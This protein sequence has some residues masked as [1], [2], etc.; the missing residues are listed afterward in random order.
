V[1]DQ[2][3]LFGG[4]TDAP[5]RERV[6]TDLASTVFVEAGAGT[7][8]TAV[9]VDRIVALVSG[10]G[11]YPPTPMR[12]IAAITFTEKAAAELRDRVR[13]ALVAA[14]LADAVNELDEA[15]ICTLHSFAQ[16]ILTEF[17]IESGL[18][19]RIEV[20][21]EISSR[22]A[23]EA[24]WRLLV[25]GLLEDPRLERPIL[26]MLASRVRLEHLR[27]VAEMLD[28]N[29]DLLDRVDAAPEV[30]AVELRPWLAALSTVCARA[31]ECRDP[32]DTMVA[33][34]E[35]L[36]DYRRQLAAA[37]DDIE[38]VR[39]LRSDKPSFRVGNCGRAASWPDIN[40]VRNA[41]ARLG[42]QRADIVQ[43]VLDGAIKQVVVALASATRVAVE[44]DA[45]RAS[46][47]STTCSCLRA[48]YCGTK[49]TARVPARAS[50]SAT[51]AF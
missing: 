13:R 1:S 25:D 31:A 16:R 45:R 14:S 33:R 8:K 15:A 32:D 22:V 24:R 40:D 17:P 47:S 44:H 2:L 12:N 5:A 29:W 37:F 39:L 42:E 38:Q 23:F 10:A 34:L 43:H 19:P 11:G 49:P 26:I 30:P 51:A 50:A 27:A 46:S 4:P 9:L 36:E 18:P 21:D 6:R 48:S 20:R 41:V 28:D 35:Q 7:G 3:A